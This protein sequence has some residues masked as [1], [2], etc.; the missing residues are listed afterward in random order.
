MHTKDKIKKTIEVLPENP[1]LEQVIEEIILL[2]K[3][4]Q[5]RKDA[6]EGC[7]YDSEQVKDRLKPNKY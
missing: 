7:V 2:D 5:G 4:E 6:D 1:T 3:I